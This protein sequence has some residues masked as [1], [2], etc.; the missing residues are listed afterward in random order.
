MYASHYIMSITDNPSIDHDTA[1]KYLTLASHMAD[2][3]SHDK[4]KK[5]GCIVLDPHTL[6]IRAC[7]FN[8][9][10]TNI[11]ATEERLQ[12]HV[13]KDYILHAEVDCICFACRNGTSLNKCVA[14]VTLHPCG[15]CARALIQAGISCVISPP[16]DYDH[17][18]W[19]HEFRVAHTLFQEAG[20]QVFY[21]EF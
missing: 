12:R 16:P 21:S 8:V 15:A 3:L 19:G 18:R 6:S 13:K 1:V 10:P 20:I 17:E 7:G 14:V 11:K 2:T 9:L 5:V 4:H